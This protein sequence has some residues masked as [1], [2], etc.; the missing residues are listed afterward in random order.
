LRW[1]DFRADLRFSPGMTMDRVAEK[2][3]NQLQKNAP[4][5]LKRP[6]RT[7]T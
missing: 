7:Q 1:L 6:R 3:R 2:A 5:S 4:K